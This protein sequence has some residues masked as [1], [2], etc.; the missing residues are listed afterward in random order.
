MEIVKVIIAGLAIGILISAPMGPIGML[1]IQRT[2]NK[3][4]ASGFFTGV[5]AAFSDLLYSLLTGFGLSFVI[6]FKKS[7]GAS[8]F[9]KCRIAWFWCVHC[10]EKP[11][12]NDKGKEGTSGEKQLCSGFDYRFLVHVLQSVDNFPYN[13]IVCTI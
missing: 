13:R 9:R 8:D 6:N 3:G 4:R 11:C 1:C 2:L 5:G 12:K 10:T 7:D